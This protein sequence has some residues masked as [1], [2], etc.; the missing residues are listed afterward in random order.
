MTL[1]A[2]L[3]VDGLSTMNET[4][5]LPPKLQVSLEFVMNTPTF[6][7]TCYG[8]EKNLPF[9]EIQDFY[10][11]ARFYKMSVAAQSAYNANTSLLR[12]PFKSHTMHWEPVKKSLTTYRYVL[13][14]CEGW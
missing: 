1:V 9:F 14:W 12:F 8:A 10:I 7:L 2:P 4:L 13:G 5:F 3:E 11:D 6:Y